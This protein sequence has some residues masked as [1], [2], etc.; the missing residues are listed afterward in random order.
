[1]APHSH[2]TLRLAMAQTPVRLRH[3][4]ITTDTINF[5]GHR[6]HGAVKRGF[7]LEMWQAKHCCQLKRDLRPLSHLWPASHFSKSC[8][9]FTGREP[10][11]VFRPSILRACRN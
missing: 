9:R 8:K 4:H 3:Y 2:V 6:L 11:A 7:E 1:M 5:R 10:C